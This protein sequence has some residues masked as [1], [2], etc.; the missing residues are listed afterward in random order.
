MRR[1]AATLKPKLKT[2]LSILLSLPLRGETAAIRVCPGGKRRRAKPSTL[3]KGPPVNV[4]R[5]IRYRCMT[6]VLT[7]ANFTKAT[8]ASYQST[9]LN[10]LLILIDFLGFNIEN[11]PFKHRQHAFQ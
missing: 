6:K 10:I 1:T 5:G 4:A 11:I 8:T 7:N 9:D 2:I 3:C